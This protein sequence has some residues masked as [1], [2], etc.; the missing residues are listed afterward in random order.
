VCYDTGLP[1]AIKRFQKDALSAKEVVHV[2]REVRLMGL[3]RGE[4]GTIQI[5]G[6]FEDDAYA[7]IVM[8]CWV[9]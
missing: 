8:V 6:F 4:P 2:A 7:Y 1:V 5:Y 9:R 3:L